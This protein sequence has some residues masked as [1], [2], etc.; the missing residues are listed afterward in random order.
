MTS[1]DDQPSI[2]KRMMDLTIGVVGM[3]G[4]MEGLNRALQ[5]DL[6]EVKTQLARER[7]LTKYA[8]RT[9]FEV[10]AWIF[11]SAL[12]VSDLG[13]RY[14]ASSGE[15]VEGVAGPACNVVF[16]TTEHGGGV[17]WRIVGATLM[18]VGIFVLNQ[19]AQV[20]S[21]LYEDTTDAQVKTDRARKRRTRS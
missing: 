1:P 3:K 2:E 4:A 9:W 15:Q 17:G 14:C 10:M 5:H 21:D 6:D 16:W 7:R 20:P 8:R 19:R 13:R 12:L 18:I 11:A